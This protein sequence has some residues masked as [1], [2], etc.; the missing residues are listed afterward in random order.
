MKPF[1][2]LSTLAVA[3]LFV[4]CTTV[5]PLVKETQDNIG[6]GN[7][8]AAL[9]SAELAIAEN[10]TSGVGQYYKAVALGS[11]GQE[12]EDVAARRGYYADALSTMEEAKSL[13]S[14]AEDVPDEA[15]N[16][17]NIIRAI[18]ADEHNSAVE[19]LTV[20]SL[21]ASFAE[22]DFLFRT[23]LSVLSHGRHRICN[24]RVRVCHGSAPYPRCR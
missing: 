23:L 9:A 19:I 13:F 24:H 2:L 8:E 14:A 15:D 10:P 11:L 5:S 3:L 21:A 16:A 7:Y 22:R 17:D 6:S 4:G 12:N 1:S 20:D 18:W